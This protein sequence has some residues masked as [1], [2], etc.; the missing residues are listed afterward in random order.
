VLNR[1]FG[2]LIVLSIAVSLAG[3]FFAY[4]FWNLRRHVN[5]LQTAVRES[6]E[7]IAFLSDA[8]DKDRRHRLV[9]LHH[10]VGRS[11]LEE[12]GLRD[13]LEQLGISVRGM[14]YGDSIGQNTD[15]CDWLPK[16]R[17]NMRGILKFQGHPNVYYGDDRTNDIVM[18][19]SCYPNSDLDADP[20]GPGDPLS[21]RKTPANYRAVFEG[22]AVEMRKHP[23]KLFIYLTAPPLVPMETT[24]ES[25]ERARTFNN[26]LVSEYASKYRSETG[27]KN[28]AV[29]D[30]FDVLADQNNLLK[31]EFRSSN[32]RDSHPNELGSVRAAARIMERFRT[33]WSEW[34]SRTD[35]L[36]NK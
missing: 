24:F 7:S 21:V 13:S 18:F 31:A 29:I 19:K 8:A 6:A 11:I 20:G 34:Q 5:R 35:S 27:P 15:M 36:S 16:F 10:S 32:P 4:Q 1:A 2:T 23:E 26:W 22:L 30:L 33:V 3:L 25:A 17:D 14:T 28:F 12:G 9:F